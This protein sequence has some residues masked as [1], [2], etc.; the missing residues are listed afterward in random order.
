MYLVE[1]NQPAQATA[2]KLPQDVVERAKVLGFVFNGDDHPPPSFYG[3]HGYYGGGG[4]LVHGSPN[5]HGRGRLGRTL[6][7]VGQ[8][9]Q[10]RRGG[11]R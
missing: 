11:K 10:P 9:L 2:A 8:M 4:Y 7:R 3:Y 5:G 6:T 1:F